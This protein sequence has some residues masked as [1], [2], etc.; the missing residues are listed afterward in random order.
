MRCRRVAGR[1]FSESARKQGGWH[2]AC[3]SCG[4]HAP[5]CIVKIETEK[6]SWFPLPIFRLQRQ[7]DVVDSMRGTG[8]WYHG[9]SGCA[10]C[11]DRWNGCGRN[12]FHEG[13]GPAGGIRT[14]PSK[15]ESNFS[16]LNR[17]KYMTRIQPADKAVESCEHF[18]LAV[19]LKSALIA[20]SIALLFSHDP[21]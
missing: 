11:G 2:E 4:M 17:K 14:I 16:Q 20:P 13:G 8:G 5:D 9:A 6:L 1:Y 19:S 18:M 21:F 10:R 15:N 7:A 3:S 12:H